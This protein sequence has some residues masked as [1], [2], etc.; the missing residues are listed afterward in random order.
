MGPFRRRTCARC[1][2]SAGG[3]GRTAG[4]RLRLLGRGEADGAAGSAPGMGDRTKFFVAPSAVAA[5]SLSRRTKS[6]HWGIRP[7]WRS[8]RC[9]ERDRRGLTNA[10]VGHCAQSITPN[11][12]YRHNRDLVNLLKIL[13]VAFWKPACRKLLENFH[14]PAVGGCTGRWRCSPWAMGKFSMPVEIFSS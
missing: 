9:P 4:R 13:R 8:R 12:S 3:S 7:G 2:R 1:G 5:S 10:Q 11:S 14:Q 6:K